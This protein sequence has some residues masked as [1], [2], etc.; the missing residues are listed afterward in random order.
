MKT[1]LLLFFTLFI[2]R[3]ININAQAPNW[4]WARN[5]AGSGSDAA[6]TLCVDLSGNVYIAGGYSSAITFGSVTLTNGANTFVTKYNNTG[7][8]LWAKSLGGNYF[9]AIEGI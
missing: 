2:V 7:N 5:G 8:V 3:A 1:K 6:K 9:A 4:D